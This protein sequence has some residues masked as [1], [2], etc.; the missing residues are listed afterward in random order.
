[1]TWNEKEHTPSNLTLLAGALGLAMMIVLMAAGWDATPHRPAMGTS[2]FT[3]THTATVTPTHTPTQTPTRTPSPTPTHTSTP[4]ATPTQTPTPSITP[5][6]SHTPTLAPTHTPTVT[7][8]P[9]PPEDH[10]WLGR[11]IGPDG[12]NQI[13][14]YYPYG[15]RGGAEEY[16]IHHAVDIINPTGTTVVAVSPGEVVFAGDDSKIALGPTTH[17]YGN[18]V[19]IR[20]DLTYEDEP[21]TVLYGHLSE[22]L[23]QEGQRVETGDVVGAVGA[24]GIALGPHLHFEVRVGGDTYAH[25][26]NPE[27]WIAPFSGMGTIAGRLIDAEGNFI[28]Q[29]L[30]TFHPAE[31]PDERWRETR[32]YYEE[33][34]IAPDP[35]WGENFVMGDAPPGDYVIKTRVDGRLYL[36][37]VA[38]QAGQTSLVVIQTED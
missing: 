24:T 12:S 2:T 11:P 27:L 38:V 26:R 7:P 13:A 14:R 8:T 10:A 28:P 4:T 30:I 5:T 16:L 3:P 32:T 22:V 33:E 18:A 15:T 23:A 21:L 1:M 31:T 34:G 9:L 35:E 36:A 6:P 20:L 37:N 17:F 25:T 29:T 19:M